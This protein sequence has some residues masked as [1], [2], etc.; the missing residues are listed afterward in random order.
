MNE[1]NTPIVENDAGVATE[2][3]SKP[4]VAMYQS[5][6]ITPQESTNDS[7]PSFLANLSPDF[8][9]DF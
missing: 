5:P 6:S 3:N 7:C 9:D 8:W 2:E 1:A 4:E